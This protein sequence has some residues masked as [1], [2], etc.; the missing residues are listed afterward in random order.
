MVWDHTVHIWH[1]ATMC[2]HVAF[3]YWL[4]SL[5]HFQ[6]D[7]VFFWSELF[8]SVIAILSEH[9][10]ENFIYGCTTKQFLQWVLF[11]VFSVWERIHLKL[12][13]ALTKIVFVA[14]L[15]NITVSLAPCDLHGNQSKFGFK[16]QI[17]KRRR[18]TLVRRSCL[19]RQSIWNRCC[20]VAR[21]DP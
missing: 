1:F 14:A 20:C 6:F 17:Q 18:I 5:F 15:S 13:A 11:S 2:T 19:R 10:T 8:F 3:I 21:P 9:C 7:E 4:Q 12:S 16:S